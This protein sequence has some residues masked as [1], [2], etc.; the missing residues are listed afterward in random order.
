VAARSYTTRS[1][2]RW[3]TNRN[4]TQWPELMLTLVYRRLIRVGVGF[5][6]CEF[7]LEIGELSTVLPRPTFLARKSREQSLPMHWGILRAAL[8]TQSFDLFLCPVHKPNPTSCRGFMCSSVGDAIFHRA[9]TAH[10]KRVAAK[11]APKSSK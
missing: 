10:S 3:L 4:I 2:L 1:A 7:S 5:S 9:N 6:V 8:T 11:A